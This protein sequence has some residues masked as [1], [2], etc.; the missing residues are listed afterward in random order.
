MATYKDKMKGVKILSQDYMKVIR[1]HDGPSSF[2]FLDPPYEKS[3][4]RLGYAEDM[5]FD[6]ERL[7]A[8]LKG[9][10]GKFLMTIND[11]PRIRELF[12]DFNQK[13]FKADTNMSSVQSH[14]KSK[15]Y[16]RHELFISNYKL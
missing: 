3:D 2:I 13:M 11:S 8:V 12:K 15:K 16:E 4:K 6:F 5:G 9:I 14:G 1:N 7:A 10:K